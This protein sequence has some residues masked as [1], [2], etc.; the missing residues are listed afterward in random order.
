MKRKKS[1]ILV[2]VKSLKITS[3]LYPFY[4]EREKKVKLKN[5][6]TVDSKKQTNRSKLMNKNDYFTIKPFL[7][8]KSLLL[9]Y[10]IPN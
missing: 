5:V 9:P 6:Y 10:I 7:P 2:R 4:C 8:D 1:Y 3:K